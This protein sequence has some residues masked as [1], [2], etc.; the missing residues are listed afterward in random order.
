MVYGLGLRASN[1]QRVVATSSGE[2][3]IAANAVSFVLHPYT[4][5]ALGFADAKIQRVS[6]L[7]VS[8]TFMEVCRSCTLNQ[9][10]KL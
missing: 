6:E 4:Y 9:Y 3:K 7:R 2:A 5:G 10:L 1:V 8:C